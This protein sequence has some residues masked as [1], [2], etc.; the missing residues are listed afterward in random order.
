MIALLARIFMKNEADATP[1][2][3][4]QAY[5][6]LCSAAGIALNLL[7]SAGKFFAGT[8]SGSIAITADAANNLSDAGSSVVTLLGFRLG[9]QKA[10]KDHPFGHGR[11]EYLSGLAVAMLIV[12]M[13]FEL[14]KSSLDKILHPQPVEAG[15]LP[16]VILCASIAVKLYMYSYNRAYGKRF[17]STAMEATA[18]DCL[19]DCVSTA[20]VLLATLVAMFTDLQI[21]G[22]CGILVAVFIFWSGLKAGKETLDPLLGTPP[23]REYVEQIRK[24]VMAHKEVVGIHD[25]VV[26]DYGPGRCM[27]SLHAEVSS[28]GNVLEIHDT[29][30]NIEKELGENL[31]CAAVI[32]MDPI[33]VDD[34]I[35]EETKKKVAMLV[36]CI[37]ETITIHDFRMVA[38]PTH[39]NLIFDAVVPFGFHHSD[40]DVR[41]RIELAVRALDENYRT[42]VT[43]ERSYAG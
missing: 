12:L 22:W 5:G 25:L 29:I 43:V 30:D 6:T 37:D 7:L 33:V 14:G 18:T 21:D 8:V 36:R 34:G 17:A 9:G 26:H 35:T 19:S 13:G 40:E 32:H 28:A 39:T 31:G 15:W 4:R 41:R 10:D 16:V 27:I 1:A 3:K 23:D 20:T 38:G 11:F 42:V 24:L 2:E